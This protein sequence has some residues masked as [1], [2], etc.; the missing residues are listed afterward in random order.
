M[1][2]PLFCAAA[3]AYTLP[4]SA[5]ES[6]PNN[7]IIPVAK[8]ERDSYDWHKRH[9][10]VLAAKAEMR[11]EIVLI[12]DSIT[13]FWGGPPQSPGARARGPESWE[14]TFAGKQVLNLGYG[15]DRTQNVLWRLDHGELDGLSPKLVGL[16][17]GTNNFT[18]T[19]NAR[20]STPRETADGIREIIRRIRAK[21]PTSE[22]VL[23]AVFPRGK[24]GDPVR[25]EI[26]AL[27]AILK[28]EWSNAP[29]VTFLDLSGKLTDA[30]GNI[31]KE[32]MSDGLHPTEKG[33]EI[34][35]AALAELIR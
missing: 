13:H 35:G 5:R 32:I 19:K 33:Y 23:T 28:A 26:S 22:I 12:G 20:A 30:N 2:L 27:N 21:S 1:K 24:A 14:K 18:S 4:A 8:L 34:W 25:A 11:P 29:R 16:M 10:A 9:I 7:A 6:A 31:P 15:W 17:I 3:F